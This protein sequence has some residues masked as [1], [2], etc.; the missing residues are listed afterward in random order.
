M[1]K[2]TENNTNYQDYLDKQKIKVLKPE[3]LPIVLTSLENAIKSNNV[4]KII[5]VTV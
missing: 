2:I 1:V 4:G 3:L 5:K